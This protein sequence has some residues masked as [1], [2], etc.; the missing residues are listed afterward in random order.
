MKKL[1]LW[2]AVLLFGFSGCAPKTAQA[3]TVREPV[4]QKIPAY[5]YTAYADAATVRQKLKERGFE[6]VAT[7][8]PTKKS[9]T[10]VVTC[11]DL[12]KAAAKPTRGHAAV[13]R[14]LVD[15]ERQ[16]VAYTNP[17]Y[18]G[19]AFLQQDYNHAIAMQVAARL[20]NALGK[21]RP[22]PDAYVYDDLAGYRFMV[23]MPGY[24]DMYEL[25]EGK[26]G[27]LLSKLESYKGGKYV[28]FKLDLGEGR[29]LVGYDLGRR[30]KKFVRKIGTQNAEI[31][32]YTILIE[33]GKATAL[34]AKYYIAIAYPLLTMGEFMTIASVP[35][36]I[37]K[38]LE[39]P[40]R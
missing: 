17:V 30:T 27:E 13:M 9:E 14:V 15:G 24:E 23:G 33:D 34:A 28:V 31:L 1:V 38:D 5:F 12:K 35:G 36:A 19:R 16:R 20:E 29:T 8:R 6:V 10:I 22:S 40:F 37:E 2:I 21:G 39:R 11:P 4:G 18:F 7:Y 3:E 25:A 26:N 32:P